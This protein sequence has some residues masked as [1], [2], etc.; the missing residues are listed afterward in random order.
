MI[1]NVLCWLLCCFATISYCQKTVIVEYE[2]KKYYPQSYF[3][4]LPS[5]QRESAKTMIEMP[6]Q[7][8]LINNGRYSICTTRKDAWTKLSA[9]DKLVTN[10]NGAFVEGLNILSNDI[11]VMKDFQEEEFYELSGSMGQRAIV[12]QKNILQNLIYSNK[13]KKID[14]IN[15]KLAFLLSKNSPQDTIKF[16]YTQEIPIIDGPFRPSDAP[17]LI[18]GYENKY[19]TIYA[20]KIS[21]REEEV[22]LIDPT[23]IKNIKLPGEY[24]ADK[25]KADYLEKLRKMDEEG[26]KQKLKLNSL[27]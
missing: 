17:G 1:K 21:Y 3:D 12:K 26:K 8:Y 24:D 23:T 6:I 11:W 19:K 9:L 14:N 27:N 7:T 13:T 15:C 20:T 22:S 2:E 4:K 25:S 16:W 18:L 5:D 10:E